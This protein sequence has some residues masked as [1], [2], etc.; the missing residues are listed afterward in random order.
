MPSA[1]SE[2]FVVNACCHIIINTDTINRVNV[3]HVSA[4][5]R[6]DNDNV[7]NYLD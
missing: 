3:L 5:M 1:A 6:H 4:A 2:Q 7:H